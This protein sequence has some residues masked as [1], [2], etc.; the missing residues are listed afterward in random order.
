MPLVLT[1]WIVSGFHNTI[2]NLQNCFLTT[3]Y[4]AI[5]DKFSFKL[6]AFLKCVNDNYSEACTITIKLRVV[7]YIH[8]YIYTYIY[9]IY[10][11]IVCWYIV[12]NKANLKQAAKIV[13][14][15]SGS[16][17][18]FFLCHI[19]RKVISTHN[20]KNPKCDCSSP[21]LRPFLQDPWQV[22][23]ELKTQIRLL[24]DMSLGL[25]AGHKIQRQF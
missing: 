20:R 25:L 22:K 3:L 12:V 5:D 21:S 7:I 17:S 13:K 9:V 10:I 16:L 4:V 24:S 1:R 8:I 19:V 2:N 14:W 6:P 11:I 15:G 18:L 23:K